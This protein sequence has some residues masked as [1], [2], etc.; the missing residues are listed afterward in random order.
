VRIYCG[1]R[2]YETPL[3][4][5]ESLRPRDRLKGPAV[6]AETNSTTIVEVGWVAE[7]TELDSLILER[8]E[9]PARQPAAGTKA[10]PVLL[11]VFNNL[12][13]SIAEQMGLRLQQTAQSVNIKERL[14]FSCAVFDR[15]GNLIANAPHIPVHL[16]SMGDTIKTVI[17]E[18]AGQMRPGDSFAINDPY[19]GGTHLPDITVV[20]PVFARD[21]ESILFYVGSRGH[22]SD[23]GGI[24]PSSMPPDS[25]SVEQEGVLFTNWK[26][27]DGGAFR[28]AETRARLT[29]GRYPARNPAQNLADLR[30]QIAANAKGEQ[31]LSRMVEDFGREVVDAYTQHVQDNAEEAVRRVIGSLKDGEFSLMTDN[32][33]V[34][35]VTVRVD[36]SRRAAVVDFTGTSSEL[37]NNFNA[38]S[39]ISTAAVLFVF[40]SLI[41]RDIPLNAGCL[42]PLEIVIPEGSMLNPRYPAAVVA[43][44]VETSQCITNALFGALGVCAAS[45]CTMNSF[46]FGNE[47]HQ[48]IETIAGGSGAGPG[49]DGTDAVHTNMTNSLITDPEVLELRYPVL[50]EAFEI[51][52]GSGG[53]GRWSGGN[54]VTRCMRFLEPMTASILSNNRRVAPFGLSGGLPGQLG[55]NR[56]ERADGRTDDLGSC[57]TIQLAAGDVFVIETPGGGGYGPP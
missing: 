28:E 8:I 31:E 9:P 27:V 12:F 18:N 53:A 29:S 13:M 15:G 24:T 43:G 44:N 3:Y 19:H 47:A 22:H 26:L 48:Y 51:R 57:A 2:W 45:Q 20:T 38:P 30:A 46:S 7:A 56:V 14:D 16:G 35:K 6:I 32:G 11:E 36:R 10:D 17:R 39:S 37:P 55:R 40:R 1:G 54:G 25:T 34:I 33:A 5:R 4:R 23:I 49:Y 50:L 41:D 42:K 52:R 21:G